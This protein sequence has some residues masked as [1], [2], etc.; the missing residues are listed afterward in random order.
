MKWPDQ[1]RT[2]HLLS[3]SIEGICREK[4]PKLLMNMVKYMRMDSEKRNKIHQAVM[5]DIL[6][7]CIMNTLGIK[8][9]R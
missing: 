1:T 4:S 3:L 7:I 8:K 5:K 2:S 9:E 6:Y